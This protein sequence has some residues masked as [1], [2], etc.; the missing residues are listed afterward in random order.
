[1]TSSHATSVCQTAPLSLP[2]INKIVLVRHWVLQWHM[3]SWWIFWP[4][5]VHVNFGVICCVWR[6]WFEITEPQ[7]TFLSLLST[8]SNL[9][10]SGT[11][12]FI[13]M[14]SYS[15]NMSFME[16]IIF[17][18]PN[19]SELRC[20]EWTVPHLSCV[21]SFLR[22]HHCLEDLPAAL[23]PLVPRGD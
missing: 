8:K 11:M 22:E 23:A 7:A 12:L 2:Y 6:C 16:S 17:G 1:M 4:V 9:L 3:K 13:C 14:S 18:S 15:L 19:C 5:N 10:V 20:T 21:L